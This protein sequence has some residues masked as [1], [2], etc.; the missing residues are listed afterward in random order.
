[1]TYIKKISFEDSPNL[2][3]FGRLRSSN[4]RTLFDSKQIFNNA[5]LFWDESLETGAG[6]TSSWS[7]D[8]AATTITSTLN[9]AGKFTRQTY[10][11]FNYQPGKSQAVLM[12][13][14]LD[15]SGGGTGVQRR[16][17]LFDDANGIFFEDDAGTIGVTIRSNV[18]GSPVDTTI[19]Q[20]NWNLDKMDGTGP[21]GVT[22]DFTKTQIFIFD[23]EWLGVGR[24]RIGFN[25][26]GQSIFCHEFLNSNNLA[27]V[28]M[29][30]PNL[31]LRYQIETTGSSPAS[32]LKCICA[33]V[34]SEDGVQPLGVLRYASTEGTHVDCVTENT[35][36]AIIGIRLK[37]GHGG[38]SIRV[39]RL[40]IQIQTGSEDGEW[41]LVFNP[42]VAGTFTYAGETNSCV[43]VARGATAN[44]VTGGTKFAGG[45]A[46]S[47]SGGAGSGGIDIPIQNAILLGED[48][49]GNV[50]EIVLCWRP[51][52]GTSDHDIEGSVTWRE[53]V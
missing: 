21:S 44:T 23:Y 5:P 7:Q 31:P 16:I 28:Y 32:S 49:A 10:M 53:L 46:Q 25:H 51:I 3:A 34:I 13:G 11:R 43:E 1:M 36:Y 15:N 17:G 39:E 47:T 24:V 6:I 29:S 42:T 8:E 45:F 37:S 27:D 50:D 20:A 33:T 4:P 19:T 2:D 14:V 40:G 18:I 52:G 48:I 30:T 35:L 41:V 22:L 9:T 38:A 26:N 12:T